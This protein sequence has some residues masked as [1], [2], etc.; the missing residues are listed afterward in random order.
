[1]SLVSACGHRAQATFVIYICSPWSL[2]CTHA[3]C[4]SGGICVSAAPMP[5]TNKALASHHVT[6]SHKSKWKELNIC[7]PYRDRSGRSTLSNQH[8]P[9]CAGVDGQ[10]QMPIRYRWVSDSPYHLWARAHLV[11]TASLPKQLRQLCGGNDPA[12]SA[13]LLALMLIFFLLHPPETVP[14]WTQRLS[15]RSSSFGGRGMGWGSS[16]RT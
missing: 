16:I 12:L 15:L 11:C 5:D 7:K 9:T 1:M 4:V 14:F 6:G 8:F 3:T 2:K 10:R 13:P